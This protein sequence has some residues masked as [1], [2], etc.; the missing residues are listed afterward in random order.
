M[1]R[2]GTRRLAVL[3]VVSAAV[4]TVG[5]AAPPPAPRASEPAAKQAVAV[6]YGGAVASVDKAAT[7][8]GTEVREPG[9]NAVDP[10][11]AAAA[12]LFIAATLIIGLVV[13]LSRSMLAKRR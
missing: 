5:A 9:G 1:G 2:P 6:G 10:A 7:A 13:V 12:F 3:T 4:V 8:P 11:I